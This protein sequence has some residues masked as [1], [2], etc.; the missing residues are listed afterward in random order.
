MEQ[1]H[2]DAGSR[3]SSRDCPVALAIAEAVPHGDGDIVSVGQ[4]TFGM[5]PSY[6][7]SPLPRAVRDFILRFDGGMEVEP[8]EFQLELIPFRGING[9][10]S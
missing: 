2:I 9:Y 6:G 1:R 4:Y 7:D 3:C 5:E 10:A 8:F